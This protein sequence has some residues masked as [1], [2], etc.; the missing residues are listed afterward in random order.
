MGIRK[1]FCFK[2]V[3][4]LLAEVRDL[5]WG[6]VDHPSS[7]EVNT[8]ESYADTRCRLTGVLGGG[9]RSTGRLTVSKGFGVTERVRHSGE[10]DGE[11]WRFLFVPAR[12]TE[13]RRLTG[14]AMGDPCE[15]S[16][17]DDRGKKASGLG[18]RLGK[19]KRFGGTTR[20]A[21]EC[22]DCL[23]GESEGSRCPSNAPGLTETRMIR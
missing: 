12:F 13:D 21:V 8:F 22:E 15:D 16:R 9:I 3:G 7:A 17:M 5:F 2:D 6:R 1:E 11:D 20:C 18:R 14:L 23:T 10:G 19:L 4:V